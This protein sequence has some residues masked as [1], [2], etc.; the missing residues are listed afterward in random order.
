MQL[1]PATARRFGVQD[2]WSVE[3]NLRGGAAYLRWL[4]DFF[5]GDVTLAVAAYNAGENAVLRAGRRIPPY[6]ETRR[7]VPKVLAWRAHYAREFAAV[8]RSRAQAEPIGP[9]GSAGLMRKT[10]AR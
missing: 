1:M 8:E 7:Y 4:T 9:D 10:A 2:V 3:D 5:R 6:E